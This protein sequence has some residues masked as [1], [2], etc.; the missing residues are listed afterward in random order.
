MSGIPADAISERMVDIGGV[1]LRL[2]KNRE[3]V[4]ELAGA[5]EA[6]DTRHVVAAFE[7]ALPG[8]NDLP[9]DKCHSYVQVF[10]LIARPAKFVRR[11]VSKSKTITPAQ[12]ET[13]TSA[14]TAGTDTDGL[15]ET[16]KGLN[17]ISCPWQLEDQSQ[18]R[19]IEEYVQGMC[20]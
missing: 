12:G 2:G 1:L 8:L 13:I 16:L 3:F 10:A 7:R 15:I 17:L 9:P 5:L 6:E 4:A 14:I 11:C 20:P 18:L 19:V